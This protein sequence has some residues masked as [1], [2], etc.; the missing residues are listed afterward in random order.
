MKR[1]TH[2]GP[3][4][5]YIT[6][7][8]GV[9]QWPRLNEPDTRFDELGVYRTS[10]IV[11][12]DEGQELADQLQAYFESAMTELQ[13]GKKKLREA[14]L[15]WEAE[16]DEDTGEE[17]GRWVFK[18][19]QKAARLNPT[20]GEKEPLFV[21]LVG[22]DAKPT[23]AQ[24]GAGSI[25]KCRVMVTAWHVPALGVGLSLKLLAV[26]VLEAKSYSGD[27]KSFGFRDETANYPSAP[28]SAAQAAEEEEEE[29][30]EDFA[31]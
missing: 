24:V 11:E 7:P 28:A 30:D 17:T 9:A 13:S 10:L 26:Q 5:L 20:T 21:Q 22:A 4:P 1:N 31:F 23:D 18:C 15:P 16:I 27:A 12:G 2:A 6:T 19:K 29:G 8:A 3:K 14:P 25:I